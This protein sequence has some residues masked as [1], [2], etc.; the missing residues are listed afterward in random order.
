[1]TEVIC[2]GYVT[3]VQSPSSTPWCF[4][5]FHHPPYDEVCCGYFVS[6]LIVERQP[7]LSFAATEASLQ[8]GDGAA[9]GP[10]SSEQL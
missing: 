2:P 5:A 4:D 1:M 6:P 9:A 8:P 7:S 10:E 3:E